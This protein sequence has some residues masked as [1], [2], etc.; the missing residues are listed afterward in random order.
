MLAFPYLI[1]VPVVITELY[2]EKCVR[3]LEYIIN[4]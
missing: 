3:K 4:K 2:S 1:F